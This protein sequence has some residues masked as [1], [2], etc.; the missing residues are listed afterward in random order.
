M[1][2]AQGPITQSV[3]TD[4]FNVRSRAR[5]RSGKIWLV[6]FQI[7]TLFGI[8]ALGAL[9]YNITNDV[10]GYAAI[11]YTVLPTFL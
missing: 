2:T 9:I 3:E 5:Q 10:A 6:F 11:E 8:L 1:E 7:S 4:E